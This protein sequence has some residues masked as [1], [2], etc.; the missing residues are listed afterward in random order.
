MQ[1]KGV[2]KGFNENGELAYESQQE[3]WQKKKDNDGDSY[4]NWY[5]KSVEYWDQQEA[6]NDGVLGGYGQVN[7]VDI[8]ESKALL[9]RI[10]WPQ[11]QEGLKVKRKLCAI[12]CGAGIGRVTQQLL[13]PYFQSVDILE[14]SE[15]LINSAKQIMQVQQINFPGGHSVGEYFCQGL[16]DFVPQKGK[17]DCM[18]IQWCLLYL[19][20]QHII[21]LLQRC[22][23]GLKKGDD[24]GYSGGVIVVKENICSDGFM[25]DES[26]SSLTRSGDYMRDL[27]QKG[28]MKVIADVK[29]KNF[30]QELFQVRMYVLRPA[31]S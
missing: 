18:W 20:D 17:Y 26:D 16:Q 10:L 3:F 8:Q 14:P 11:I 19:T 31:T 5:Q 9:K 2:M 27:F 23:D 6:S 30:P 25:T 15:H 29:Q 12:D 1:Q 24:S 7:Q 28:G 4:L 13:M 22:I 21:Q